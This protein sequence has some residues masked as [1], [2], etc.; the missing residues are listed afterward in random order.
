MLQLTFKQTDSE[1]MVRA[2]ATLLFSTLTR[3]AVPQVAVSDL[4]EPP[5]YGFTASATSQPVGPRFVRI[6]DLKDGGIDWKHVPFCECQEPDKYTLSENDILFAR[7]GATTGKTHLVRDPERAVFASYL[8]RLRPKPDIE[9]GYLYA[10]FQSDNYWS[11]ISEGKEGSAQPN[12][13]GEKLSRLR[14]PA[15][16]REIQRAISDVLYCVRRR[17]DGES[18]ELPDLPPPLTDQRAVLIRLER[19]GAQVHE[20]Q[21]LRKSASEEAWALSR[22]II[23]KVYKRLASKFGTSRLAEACTTITD[24]DHNTPSFGETGVRFIFV[25][26]VS[27]EHLHFK[28]S[29]WVSNEYFKTLRPQRLPQRGDLL[30]SA[31][32]ATLGVPAIVDSD[33]PFCFQRHIA[34]LKPDRMKLDGQFGWH[35]LRSRTVFER[36][37]SSTTG[38]AQP[39]IPL[40][41]IRELPIPLPP[42]VDQRLIV[43][44]LNCLQA[45]ADRLREL[46]AETT[47][48]LDALLP[49][50]LSRAFAGDL[51]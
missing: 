10:F 29:K 20:A 45:E 14:I 30:Y 24:G 1:L 33:E 44:D 34:I 5:Q 46:Q 32:G 25:G 35:M 19:L 41:A 28:D 2:A 43:N 23:E 18:V 27:S 37:W 21:A 4:T 51:L 36:A 50:V 47:T 26:N 3:H 13:N 40:R 6:T 49:S 16:Q 39:T 42:L 31:V 38:S 15:V 17:Q 8:I 9:A 11:Q 48:E 22:A 12:V 7:T